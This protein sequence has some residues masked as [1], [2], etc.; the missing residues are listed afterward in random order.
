M[1]TPERRADVAFFNQL[2]QFAVHHV[3]V[4]EPRPNQSAMAAAM[5]G[6]PLRNTVPVGD[7]RGLGQL[8]R[9][10]RINF[11]AGP[12][13]VEMG[14]VALVVTLSQRGP[15]P[16]LHGAVRFEQIGRQLGQHRLPFR[17][18]VGLDA[19]QLAGL[20]QIG[21]DFPAHRNVHAGVDHHH[22]RGFRLPGLFS[23]EKD[24]TKM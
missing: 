2:P 19:Q 12:G 14:D 23:G 6:Q 9:A 7:Q 24:G 15:G 13:A 1:R 20:H 16:F 11:V 4:F 8:R 21:Q 3:A 17:H 10:V 5:S 22:A 18:A